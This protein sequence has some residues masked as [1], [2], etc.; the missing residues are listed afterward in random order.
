MDFRLHAYPYVSYTETREVN[1]LVTSYLINKHN[2][3]LPASGLLFRASLSDLIDAEICANCL[4]FT[5][6]SY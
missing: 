6:L 3:Y 1:Q 4:D 5:Y 2:G